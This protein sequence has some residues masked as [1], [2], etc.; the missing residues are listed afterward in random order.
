M[1]VWEFLAR[2]EWPVIA[3]IALWLFHRPIAA[4]IA[5]VNLKKL[6]AWGLKAEFEKG[7]DKVEKLAPPKEEEKKEAPKIQAEETAPIDD[8]PLP[9]QP[10]RSVTPEATVLDVW[11]WLEADMRA[12]TDAIHPRL[13]GP[14]WTPPLKF[15]E[16]ARELGLNDDE[17]ESLVTLRELRNNIAHSAGTSISWE[18]ALRF[19]EAALRLLG[20]MKRN[21]GQRY[22]GSGKRS[23]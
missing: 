4:M 22:T 16:A 9:S 15:E 7:L 13:R 14:L 21:W 1:T 5:R 23:S 19:R 3:G 11:S 8:E 12:M 17:V 6:D 20:K 10:G 18:D 2:S